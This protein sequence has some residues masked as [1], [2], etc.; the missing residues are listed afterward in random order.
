MQDN[1]VK[2]DNLLVLQKALEQELL[3]DVVTKLDLYEL[4]INEVF[5]N[6]SELQDI[7]LLQIDENRKASNNL[8]QIEIDAKISKALEEFE[9]YIL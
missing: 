5:S 4:K 8:T 7:M 3:N 2:N 6:I 9:I 1:Q